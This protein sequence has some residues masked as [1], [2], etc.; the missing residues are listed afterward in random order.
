MFPTTAI[1]ETLSECGRIRQSCAVLLKFHA[2]SEPS[3]AQVK[4][5]SRVAWTPKQA[6]ACPAASRTLV[7]AHRQMSEPAI[8]SAARACSSTGHRAQGTGHRAQ[9]DYIIYI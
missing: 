4:A 2:I 3:M 1:D 7:V 8:T 9:G 5:T 6:I